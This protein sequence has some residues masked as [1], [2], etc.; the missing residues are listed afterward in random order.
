[1]WGRLL[2]LYFR[3]GELSMVIVVY[4][5]EPLFFRVWGSGMPRDA[6]E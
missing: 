4:D 5:R 1:V 6:L 3:L 2:V